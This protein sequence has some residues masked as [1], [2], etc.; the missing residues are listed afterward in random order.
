MAVEIGDY[1]KTFSLNEAFAGAR[2]GFVKGTSSGGV[3][4][5]DFYDDTATG[6]VEKGWSASVDRTVGN[7]TVSATVFKVIICGKE[8]VFFEDGVPADSSYVQQNFDGYDTSVLKICT[9]PM[10]AT[11]GTT[12]EVTTRAAGSGENPII[13]SLEPRDQYAMR[14]LAEMLRTITQPDAADAGNIAYYCSAAYRWAQGM[15]NAAAAARENSGEPDEVDMTGASI[16]EQLLGSIVGALEDIKDALPSGGGSGSG[17]S[18]GGSGTVTSVGL[19][20]PS[21]TFS[22]SN[23]PITTNGELVVALVSQSA[24]LVFASPNGSA[25]VP[26]WRSLVAADIPSLAASK[27]TSGTFDAARIP[28]LS[29]TKITSDKPT[30]L[31]GYGIT[32]AYISSGTINL[33]GSTITPLTQHQ[34]LTNYVTFSDLASEL[35]GYVTSVDTNDMATKTWVG[36]NALVKTQGK[37][38]EDVTFAGGYGLA[39]YYGNSYLGRLDVSNSR[40]TFTDGSSNVAKR[41]L[42][43]GDAPSFSFYASTA[44]GT[45]IDMSQTNGLDMKVRSTNAGVYALDYLPMSD[46]GV[47]NGK[48]LRLEELPGYDVIKANSNYNQ[49]YNR[50]DGNIDPDDCRDE[51]YFKGLV[52]WAITKYLGVYKSDSSNITLIGSARPNST[53]TVH[54]DLYGGSGR[55]PNAADPTLP[56]YCSGMYLTLSGSIFIFGTIEGAW[57]WRQIN[58]ASIDAASLGGVAAA[59]YA[60]Q[61][62]VNSQNYLSSV[63]LSNYLSVDNNGVV[64]R[65]IITDNQLYLCG[66]NGSLFGSIVIC[67]SNGDPVDIISMNDQ[68]QLTWGGD[69][70]AMYS[71]INDMATETWV[72]QQHFSHGHA[73]Y[74]G[75]TSGYANL[76]DGDFLRFDMPFTF[77]PSDGGTVIP[78]FLPLSGGTVTGSLNVS[79]EITSRKLILAGDSTLAAPHMSIAYNYHSAGRY[80][81]N[82]EGLVGT[83]PSASPPLYYNFDAG[84]TIPSG[85][86]YSGSDIRKKDIVSEERLAVEDIANIPLVKFTMK[87]DKEKK[88]RFGSIAQ[89]WEKVIPETVIEDGDGMKAM[90]YGAAAMAAGVTACREI[91]ELKEENRKLREELAEIKK[92]LTGK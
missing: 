6:I 50:I 13:S 60:T 82:F 42:L 3:Y 37:L 57:Y 71:D 69:R 76:N 16:S 40:L 43:Q 77:D 87:D 26:T 45:V 51:A 18:G 41:V 85:S 14:V 79:N 84:I 31:A 86:T 88:V 73:I 78:A 23:T 72:G 4:T 39:F 24:N 15:M 75:L 49:D 2:I 62:W 11:Q 55:N 64:D 27:I 52:R 22:V 28:N 10:Q 8:V 44:D 5:Y 19:S 17:G 58:S 67:D 91:V 21:G 65:Q 90:D 59:N 35:E 54:I 12:A 81:L 7:Q 30:T 61:S 56:M 68:G 38:T 36:Q 80:I 70:V 53:G 48:V 89:E 46:V 33:G 25:G 47:Q 92:M 63:T 83:T 74:G 9:N 29:W 66:G 20:M 34:S 1:W 32:D